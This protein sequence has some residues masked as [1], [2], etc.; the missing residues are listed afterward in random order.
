MPCK[1]AINCIILGVKFFRYKCKMLIFFAGIQ[2]YLKLSYNIEKL[3]YDLALQ[4]RILSKW[5][6]MKYFF[7]Q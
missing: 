7:C 1:N 2:S 5:E 3:V 6:L 4:D